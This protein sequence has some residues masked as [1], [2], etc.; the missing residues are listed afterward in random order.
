M[1]NCPDCG[2][3]GGNHYNDCP[4]DGTGGGY[5]GGPGEVFGLQIL[6]GI[7][8]FFVVPTTFC[9]LLVC[10]CPVVY[11]GFFKNRCQETACLQARE[12]PEEEIA[13]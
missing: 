8:A 13:A 1:G 11:C 3:S 9:R 6:I 2:G 5:S 12:R 7:A 10:V 4:Y